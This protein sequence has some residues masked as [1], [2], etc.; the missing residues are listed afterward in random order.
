M[1]IIWIILILIVTAVI[2]LS[3]FVFK[4]FGP[5]T[6][7]QSVNE[8]KSF[9]GFDFEDDF[10]VTQHAAFTVHPDRPIRMLLLFKKPAFEKLI[11]F[12][13]KQDFVESES[14]VSDK[15]WHKWS[16]RKEGNIYLKTYSS[17][18]LGSDYPFCRFR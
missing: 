8:I 7:E 11:E 5:P 15:V 9:L 13:A 6:E 18:H 3:Y 2:V 17:T 12:V 14:S 4:S 1:N 16:W 10:T